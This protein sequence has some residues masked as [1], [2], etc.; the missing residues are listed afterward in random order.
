MTEGCICW[1]VALL[2]EAKPL[3]ERLKM[4]LVSTNSLHPIY[5]NETETDWLVLSGVGQ[6]NAASGTASLYHVCP[7]SNWSIWVNIGIAGGIIGD[8]GDPFYINSICQASTNKM[9]YPFIFP[10]VKIKRANLITCES[11][12][13]KYGKDCL[14]DM[15]AWSFYKILKKKVTREFI[16]VFKVISD[17]SKEG[18]E[19]LSAF[20]QEEEDFPS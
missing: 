6:L 18:M 14:F 8:V 4:K 10:Y 3:I 11:P 19:N 17:N 2:P 5:T 1:V 7:K 13:K 12:E 9:C 16:A 20:T 15:E